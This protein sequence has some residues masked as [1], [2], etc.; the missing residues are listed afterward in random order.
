MQDSIHCID[1][2]IYCLA[3]TNYSDLSITKFDVT[4]NASSNLFGYVL[5][6]EDDTQLD[7]NK[8]GKPNGYN[9]SK[10]KNNISE[11]VQ[12]IS[13]AEDIVFENDFGDTVY[14]FLYKALPV[15]NNQNSAG[16]PPLIVM[17]HGG[18]TGTTN[19][20][21]NN[22][23]QFWTS[24]GYTVVDVNYSGSTTYGREYRDR[25][26]H[27]WGVKDVADCA[28]AA[29]YLIDKDLVDKNKIFI[30]GSSAGGLVVLTALYKYDVFTAGVALYP[31][32]N[33]VTFNDETHNF[34]KFYNNYLIG[35]FS[36]CKQ[37]Y[38]KR[39]PINFADKITK[40]VLLMQ[41]DA[42][43][44][45]P[46]QHTRDLYEKLKNNHILNKYIEIAG[47]GH[48]FR[49]IDALKKSFNTELDFYELL[50]SLN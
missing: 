48:G 13:I 45:I 42:D 32:S 19:T 25:L 39:S 36:T 40:P 7:K 3:S 17:C 34:E 49:T 20:G 2:N 8:P 10:I 43:N 41:G 4:N 46:V 24:R 11:I 18:P 35:D 21:Y 1:S 9:Q 5:N 31:V 14:G 28:A 22:K 33:L 47:E 37:E 16:L 6:S 12:R 15:N 26:K 44:V 30:R 23:I 38:I 50:D 29:K 27:N